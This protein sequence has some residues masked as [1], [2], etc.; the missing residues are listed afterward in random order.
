[1]HI[2]PGLCILCCG[3]STPGSLCSLAGEHILTKHFL[4]V[5]ASTNGTHFYVNFVTETQDWPHGHVTCAVA[6]PSPTLAW[7]GFMFLV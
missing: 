2:L 5:P 3:A 7:K 1:M 6:G 4:F